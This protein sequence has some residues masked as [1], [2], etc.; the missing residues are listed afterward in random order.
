MRIKVTCP[1][2][3]ASQSVA[4]K[5]VG[6]TVRCENCQAEFV[7]AAAAPSRAA[8]RLLPWIIIILVVLVVFGGAG[9]AAYLFIDT[10][11]Q[12]DFTE[13]GGIFSARFPG[14]PKE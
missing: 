11:T 5:G 12:T 8:R 9:L 2:C 14:D 1:E 3:R 4:D 13:P 7:A 6:Q 10:P